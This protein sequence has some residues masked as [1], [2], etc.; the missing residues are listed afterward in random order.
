MTAHRDP[1]P[2]PGV[3]RPAN[4]EAREQAFENVARFRPLITGFDTQ[5]V[6]GEGQ[7]FL[8][9]GAA[10]AIP[11]TAAEDAHLEQ[12]EGKDHPVSADQE[13]CPD[14]DRKCRD[15]RKEDDVRAPGPGTVG[16]E[17]DAA[18][19]HLVVEGGR[20]HVSRHPAGGARSLLTVS[21]SGQNLPHVTRIN[22]IRGGGAGR[23][24]QPQEEFAP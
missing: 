18:R 4:E 11:E 16:A 2:V 13:T 10:Y 1:G 7:H 22:G 17:D 6:S 23:W 9:V 12:I 14:R 5:L 15:D 24:G 20:D 19:T 8:S 3:T 21:Y